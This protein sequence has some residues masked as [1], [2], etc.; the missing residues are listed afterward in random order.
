MRSYCGSQFELGYCVA[1]AKIGLYIR[2]GVKWTAVWKNC[3]FAQKSKDD[4]D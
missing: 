2:E 4:D 1:R 3:D